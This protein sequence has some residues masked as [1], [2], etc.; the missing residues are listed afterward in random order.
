MPQVGLSAP[1]PLWFC[2]RTLRLSTPV[3][4]ANL[5]IFAYVLTLEAGA[6]P[7]AES[8]FAPLFQLGRVQ[9]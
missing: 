9:R 1:L 6:T 7:S 2:P 4:R 8:T 3:C 5:A